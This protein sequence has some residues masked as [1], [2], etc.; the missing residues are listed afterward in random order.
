MSKREDLSEG[1]FKRVAKYFLRDKKDIKSLSLDRVP[2]HHPFIRILQVQFANG[3]EER[4]V[5]KILKDGQWNADKTV[6]DV[7]HEITIQRELKRLGFTTRDYLLVKTDSNDNPVRFPFSVS[8]YLKGDP[9]SVMPISIIS[10]VI[11][12]VFDYLYNLHSRTISNSFGYSPNSKERYQKGSVNFGRFE[13]RYLLADI[14][15][16]NIAFND[17]ETKD[18]MRS[19][20]FLNEAELFCLCHCDATLSNIIW[21]D[22]NVYLVDWTYSHFTEPTYDIAYLIFWLLEFKLL[23]QAEKE[24]KRAFK[25]YQPL[26]FDI[27][28]RFPFYLAHKYIEFGRIKGIH[29]IEQGKQ[30][31]KEIPTMSLEDLLS[32]FTKISTK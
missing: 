13:S 9:L 11:P 15:R 7:F 6:G 26:G 4:F 1:A 23:N 22:P 31:L 14:K 18:L 27:I 28:S 17:Q 3:R 20:D 5:V 19:I 25:R 12:K 29:Y 32:S 2:D 10:S 30:L 24:I 16:Y 8:T 21:D